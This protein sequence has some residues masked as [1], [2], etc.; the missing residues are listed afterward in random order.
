M[1]LGYGFDDRENARCAGV[2][3]VE[4]AAGFPTPAFARVSSEPLPTELAAHLQRT[5]DDEAGKSGMTAALLTP[6]G[7]LTGATGTADGLRAIRPEDQMAIGSIT[8]TI[9]AAQVM[10]LV[11]AGELSLDDPAADHLPSGLEFDSN[12]ATIG[13]LL[14]MRSGIPDYVDAVWDTL[15]TDRLRVWTTD[16]LL[17]RVVADRTPAGR[18]FEYS[19]TNSA[20]LGLILEQV[21]SRPVAEMLRDGVLSGAGYERLIYQPDERPTEPMATP[22]GAP[23]STLEKGGGYL[24]SIA[25]VTA[26][27]AAGAM[28]S[29]AVTLSR[30]WGRLCG[31]QVVSKASL[32][33]MTSSEDGD[34]YGLGIQV[35]WGEH[36]PAVGHGGLQVGFASHAIRLRERGVVVVLLANSEDADASYVADALVRAISSRRP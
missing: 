12:D 5:L 30:W 27:G 4:P 3:R 15:S 9:V 18:E 23:A 6:E 29:D 2:Q 19:S 28:A 32:D 22:D 31:G 11:E 36:G 16:E 8:K 1:L 33:A 7:S 13:D 35:L 24:P 26:A 17:A 25:A 34:G 21:T 10:Q 20:L 14:G